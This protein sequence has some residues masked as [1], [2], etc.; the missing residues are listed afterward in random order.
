LTALNDIS[1]MRD[2]KWWRG[3]LVHIRKIMREHLAIAMG[4]VSYKASPYASWDCVR[5]HQDQQKA[6]YEY[7]RQCQLIDEIT[8]EEADLWDMAKKSLSN[9]AIR[10]HELMVRCRGCEDI[11]NE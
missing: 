11:G 7:I 6:N 8:G 9:P 1:R 4:Q 10:R 2:E 5:E 3:R